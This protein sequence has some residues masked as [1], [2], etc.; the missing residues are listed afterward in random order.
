ME[1]QS[2]QP[3]F[4][5]AFLPPP[6]KPILCPRCRSWNLAFIT[7]YHKCI[8]ARIILLGLLTISAVSL[9][10]F[11]TG[12]EDSLGIAFILLVP[13]AFLA[14]LI[15][16]TESKTHVQCVCRDCGNVWLHK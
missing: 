2:N 6:P 12:K 7:E 9:V 4:D 3:P 11:F 14:I 8:W 1:N 15:F 10:S 5:S 16:I 13:E